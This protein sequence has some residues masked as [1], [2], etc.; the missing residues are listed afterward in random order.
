MSARL[1]HANLVV[2]EIDAT[3]QFLQTV[4]PDFEIRFD[5]GRR[6]TRVG[7]RRR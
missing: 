6:P 3:I 1:E 2:R 7:V 4:F 5:G